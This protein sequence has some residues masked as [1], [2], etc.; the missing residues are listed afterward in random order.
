LANEVE[1]ALEDTQKVVA[2]HRLEIELTK[3]AVSTIKDDIGEMKRMMS[4]FV[5][6]LKRSYVPRTEFVTLEKRVD[7]LENRIWGLVVAVLLL[8]LGWVYQAVK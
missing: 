4:N 8:A 7:S 5:E 3:Q 6:E 1:Q 2:D